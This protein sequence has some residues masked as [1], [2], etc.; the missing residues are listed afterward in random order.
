MS[1]TVRMRE[2][3]YVTLSYT[4]THLEATREGGEAVMKVKASPKHL[5]K[6][7]CHLGESMKGLGLHTGRE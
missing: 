5:P 4:P 3:K 1:S 7:P 2:H 6:E